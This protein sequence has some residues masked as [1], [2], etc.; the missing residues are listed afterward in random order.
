M[1]KNDISEKIL[2]NIEKDLLKDSIEKVVVGAVIFLSQKTPL[3]LRRT[4]SDFM[5]GLVELPSGTV[6]KGE[7]LI[8]ALVR[9]VKEETGLSISS[10][11]SYIGCFDYLL[12]SG[13]KTRQLSFMVKTSDT[14][15]TL[16]SE[17]DAFYTFSTSTREF[18]KL[19]ISDQTKNI[20]QTACKKSHSRS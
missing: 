7:T 2:N 1:F 3:L 5:G 19:K 15:V 11:D 6:D 10:V 20:I 16:S 9:E 13:K 12:G 17:H 14:N 8:E 18:K 4:A